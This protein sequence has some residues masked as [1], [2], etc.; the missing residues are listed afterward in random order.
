M[1][2]R[3]EGGEER[4]YAGGYHE[5]CRA[6]GLSKRGV[7]NIVAELQQ[8]K[9]VLLQKAPGH[10]R[11]QVSVYQVRAESD[12]LAGWYAEG[13]RFVLGKGRILLRAGDELPPPNGKIC[14]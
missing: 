2:Q 11:S 12:V 7:Q 6:T 14:R 4:L 3:G 1:Y 8:K 13:Y 10:H 5:L 9:A